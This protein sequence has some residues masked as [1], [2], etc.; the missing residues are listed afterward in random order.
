MRGCRYISIVLAS[1]RRAQCCR[2]KLCLICPCLCSAVLV[3]VKLLLTVCVLNIRLFHHG[4]CLYRGIY[5]V[6]SPFIPGYVGPCHG[7]RL[8]VQVR[9]QF[10][11][12]ISVMCGTGTGF[13]P[14]A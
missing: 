4:A 5:F 2:T 13:P 11:A 9:I 14:I 3:A 1:V 12:S 8:T 10:H 6:T 7:R